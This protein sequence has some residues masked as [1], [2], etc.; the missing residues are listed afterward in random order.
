MSSPGFE[1]SLDGETATAV[2][3]A[4][5]RPVVTVGAFYLELRCELRWTT[6][7]AYDS[8]T[9]RW[10]CHVNSYCDIGA[11]DAAL[12]ALAVTQPRTSPS[13]VQRCKRALERLLVT[14]RRTR[15][16]ST[17]CRGLSRSTIA[18]ATCRRSHLAVQH[19][20]TEHSGQ[21]R[22]ASGVDS[23]QCRL[24]APP[25]RCMPER[26]KER[27]ARQRR[28]YHRFTDLGCDRQRLVSP[29]GSCLRL[30]R[31]RKRGSTEP[32]VLSSQ[33]GGRCAGASL[34]RRPIAQF[35]TVRRCCGRPVSGH[36]YARD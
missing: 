19:R 18:V 31:E 13:T 33:S 26:L 25:N 5:A 10:R 21:S 22:R 23:P 16:L 6:A 15:S 36:A 2:D 12:C 24:T 27:P 14:S 32:L 1:A 30:A 34:S 17:G 29:P 7:T 35:S 4:T 20:P 9:S 11:T 3:S 28:R 8:G